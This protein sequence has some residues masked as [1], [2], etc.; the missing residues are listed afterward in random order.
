M[1]VDA[2]FLNYSII[3]GLGKRVGLLSILVLLGNELEKS[4]GVCIKETAI[5]AK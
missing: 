2:Q 3:N 5:G 1:S 4:V